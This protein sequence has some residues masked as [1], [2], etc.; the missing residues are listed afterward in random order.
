MG[1][2][3]LALL[4]EGAT[5][6]EPEEPEAPSP[7][8][9]LPPGAT[10]DLPGDMAIEPP[11]TRTQKLVNTLGPF[12]PGIFATAASVP[13]AASGFAAPGVV[14]AAGL[15]G[16][17]GES[18]DQLARRA[19][20]LPTVETSLEAAKEIT[21][22]GAVEAAL[23]LG[24]GM[25]AR[26]L[27]SPATATAARTPPRTI[28]VMDF[29]EASGLEDF[30]PTIGQGSDFPMLQVI[31]N[32]TE[33]SLTGTRITAFKNATKENV[34][35]L[36]RNYVN[37]FAATLTDDM[38]VPALRSVL[39]DRVNVMNVLG[40]SLMEEITNEATELALKQSG[41]IHRV[42][43]KALRDFR[44]KALKE[45]VGKRNIDITSDGMVSFADARSIRSEILANLR[46]LKSKE[47]NIDLLFDLGDAKRAAGIMDNSIMKSLPSPLLK[48]KLRTA[49]L[50]F[51]KSA[52]TKMVK[53]LL[54]ESG[55]SPTGRSMLANMT[56][57]DIKNIKKVLGVNVG[58]DDPAFRVLVSSTLNDAVD[59]SLNP[60]QTD[61][62]GT[63]LH[64][65]LFGKGQQ[66][67]TLAE[68]KLRLL[69]GA[70]GVKELKK[71]VATY[72]SIQEAAETGVGGAAAQFGQMGAIRAMGMAAF[73]F[74]GIPPLLSRILTAK[75]TRN[76][77]LRGLTDIQKGRMRSAV[78]TG[79][80][81][82]TLD[83]RLKRK[84]E[85][86]IN[87]LTEGD[88]VDRPTQGQALGAVA[89]GL[90][91]L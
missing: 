74:T 22:S 46:K 39:E 8:D 89:P 12:F 88:V 90:P 23:E 87:K 45:I 36:T 37:S 65:A 35:N 19:V 86:D 78:A 53:R 51:N 62:I 10:L 68:E 79:L 5:L 49:N 11:L 25:I 1:Q 82:S 26:G 76:L 44:P 77:F 61:V 83:Q 52:K 21:L 4:P 32:F 60:A 84:F 71:I 81:L 40:A 33:G 6:D 31:E 14:G 69:V 30:G 3:P 9:L 67:G 28:A 7:G 16:A 42:S 63:A 50:V 43:I 47:L 17:F 48:S 73:A 72:I 57:A 27:V 64:R 59:K 41:D 20:D 66:A 75:S 18:M 91:T 15:G 56:E 54:V 80:R 58:I 38:T 70:D 24:G 13:L 55:N 29:L 85:N 2:N 34:D